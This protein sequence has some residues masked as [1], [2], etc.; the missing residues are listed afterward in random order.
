MNLR[1]LISFH[2][3]WKKP[4]KV[5]KA[6]EQNGVSFH[7]LFPIMIKLLW[8]KSLNKSRVITKSVAGIHF[9]RD[10][11]HYQDNLL[12]FSLS[13]SAGFHDSR[14]SLTLLKQTNINSEI[15]NH[16]RFSV[17][18]LKTIDTRRSFIFFVISCLTN[19]KKWLSNDVIHFDWIHW[20]IKF[21]VYFFIAA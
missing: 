4:L 15:I 6:T 20:K 11:T 17:I 3:Q 19:L 9:P 16:W 2:W 10:E 14:L 13:T 12:Q 21:R 1:K 7:F 5:F 8:M 18:F